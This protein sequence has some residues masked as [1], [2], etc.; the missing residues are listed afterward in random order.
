M[1]SLPTGMDLSSPRRFGK[2][3]DGIAQLLARDSIDLLLASVRR[4]QPPEHIIERT[5]FKHQHNNMVDL[6]KI[7]IHGYLPLRLLTLSA[8]SW[9][10]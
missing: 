8:A 3:G 1:V 6:L 4:A 10:S 2:G 5:V 9:F 7:G